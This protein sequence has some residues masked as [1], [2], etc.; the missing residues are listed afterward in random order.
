MERFGDRDGLWREMG[1]GVICV[2][3]REMGLGCR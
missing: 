2:L 1:W 3:E